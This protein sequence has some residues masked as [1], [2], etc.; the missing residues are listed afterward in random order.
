MSSW[1]HSV[2]ST[3]VYAL[4]MGPHVFKF[5]GFLF[6]RENAVIPKSNIIEYEPSE[7]LKKQNHY[8]SGSSQTMYIMADLNPT[9]K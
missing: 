1:H 8:L 7:D 2:A 5:I 9:G 6:F 4:C 3:Y